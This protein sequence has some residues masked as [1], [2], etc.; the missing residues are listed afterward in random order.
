MDRK[1]MAEE[2]RA[3]V[4]QGFYVLGD[5][6]RV[7]I[8]PLLRAACDGTTLFRPDQ[9]QGLSR[10]QAAAPGGPPRIEVT[11]ES[12][13]D[14]GRRLVEREKIDDVAV[15]NFASARNPGGGWLGGARAQE[16]D[17]AVSSALVACLM[18][19]PAYYEANRKLDS[20]VYT[21]HLIYSPRVPFFRHEDGS[22]MASPFPLSV[23]TAPAPNAGEHLRRKPDGAT[24]VR[25]TL[26]RRAAYVLAVAK[27]RRHRTLVLG[28][29][30]CGVF[31][32][33][34]DQVAGIFRGWLADARFR[35]AFDRIV[36]AVLDRSAS[37][38]TLR[39]FERAFATA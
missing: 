3:A 22:F 38:D 4:E 16:E 12:T 15:L 31:R 7:D 26:E 34:P 20:L 25:I 2:T 23:I 9:L 11:G 35:G 10:T 1:A 14:A 17:L 33:D 24:L 37:R 8:S 29:W 36:F 13:L 19:A 39:A 6:T 5:G 21:D 18:K 28:A 27:E 30:G 32:N